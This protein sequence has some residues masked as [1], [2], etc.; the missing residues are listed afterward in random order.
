MH[1]YLQFVPMSPGIALNMLRTQ[2]LLVDDC[3]ATATLK[4]P[5][6]D[7]FLP[8]LYTTSLLKL[9]T[10]NGE[11]ALGASVIDPVND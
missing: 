7:S 2:Q 3:C 4:S 1:R 9:M 5:S 8:S 10:F 11:A 6:A